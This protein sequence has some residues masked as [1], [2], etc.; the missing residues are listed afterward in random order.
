MKDFAIDCLKK[1]KSGRQEGEG[2][3]RITVRVVR[4]SSTLP[5]PDYYP[6]SVE[7]EEYEV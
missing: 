6:G 1:S 5:R 3:N 4:L 2:R 7:T